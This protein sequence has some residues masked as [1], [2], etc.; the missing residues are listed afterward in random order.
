[1]VRF[2]VPDT[3]FGG[4]SRQKGARC[5]GAPGHEQSGFFQQFR[6][7]NDTAAI[8]PAIR[9][10]RIAGKLYLLY[11]VPLFR[12][13]DDPLLGIFNEGNRITVIKCIPVAIVYF[14]AMIH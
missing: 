13:S 3:Q 5:K 6:A 14:R 11:T 9:F 4:N 2:P 8:H 10:L 1:M 12:V 7:N